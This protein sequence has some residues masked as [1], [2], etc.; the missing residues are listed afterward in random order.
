MPTPVQQALNQIDGRR[1]A[2]LGLDLAR[3][4]SPTGETR[5]VAERFAA[6]LRG[7]GLE[8]DL[9]RDFPATPVVIASLPGEGPRTLI[10]NGHLDTVPIPHA[11]P[12]IEGDRL[13]G[14]GTFDMKGP[15]ASVIEMLRAASEAGLRFPGRIAVI[16][17]GLHEAPGGRSEDLIAAIRAGRIAGDAVIVCETGAAALPVIQLGM[18]IFQA[19]FRRE[20]DATHELQTALGTPHPAF[21]AAE[22]LLALEALGERLAAVPLPYVGSETVFTGQAHCGDFYNRFP[23]AAQIEG[24]RRYAP[25]RTADEAAAE[26][27]A[28]LDPI[29][30]RRGLALE[31]TF[32]KVR[33]GCRI[34][35][36]HPLA[37]ALRAAYAGV[38]GRQL[39]L[40]GNRVVADASIFANDAGIPAVYH[41]PAGEGAHGDRE[42]VPIAELERAARVYLLAAWNYLNEGTSDPRPES[43]QRS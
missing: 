27:R 7:L 10:F 15:L 16:A 33:D 29:A 42:S 31:L 30:A 34:D 6:E 28:L 1:A 12:A 39:P 11:A 40:C 43:M 36:E 38:T 22:A 9:F 13:T 32:S 3:I 17:H 26:L 20:G 14:R 19:T 5:A 24:T 4:D 18:G 37:R 35:A 21:A 2:A 25:E 41:G 8:V 23:V